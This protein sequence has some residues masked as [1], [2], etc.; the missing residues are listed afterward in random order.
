MKS[1]IVILFLLLS[2]AF[3]SCEKDDSVSTSKLEGKYVLNSVDLKT[4]FTGEAEDK[5]TENV[6]SKGIYYTFEANGNYTTNAYWSI[7][8]IDKDTKV[9][10]GTYTVSGDVITIKYTDSELGKELNQ[11]MQIKTNNGTDLVLYLGK[12]E[13]LESFKGASAGLDAFTAAFVSIFLDSILK[14]EYTLT[15]KKA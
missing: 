2:T 15:F 3:F 1:K 6:A 5:S 12:T 4:Q 14:F 7:G 13:L 10:T 11:K 9:N 8:E